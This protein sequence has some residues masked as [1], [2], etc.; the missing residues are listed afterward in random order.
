MFGIVFFLLEEFFYLGGEL[1]E[2]LINGGWDV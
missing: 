1:V 2:A